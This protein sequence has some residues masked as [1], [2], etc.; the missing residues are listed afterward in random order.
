MGC[1]EFEA[2]K[3]SK[4]RRRRKNGRREGAD[5]KKEVIYRD[6]EGI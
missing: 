1:T 4:K 2:K 5:P 6:Q 3:A